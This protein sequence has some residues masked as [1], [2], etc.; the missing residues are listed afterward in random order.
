[1]GE[2]LSAPRRMYKSTR[3]ARD[4][5]GKRDMDRGGAGDGARAPAPELLVAASSNSPCPTVVVN[6]WHSISRRRASTAGD[7]VSSMQIC[8]GKIFIT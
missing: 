5:V 4:V 6:T 2:D 8:Q 7:F 1:M 3:L